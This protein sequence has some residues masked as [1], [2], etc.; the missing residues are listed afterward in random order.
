MKTTTLLTQ[1][2]NLAHTQFHHAE[3]TPLADGD[4]RLR[5][6]QFSFTANNVTYASF[7]ESMH[8]WQFF[9]SP[10]DGFGIIPV[11][12]FATVVQSAHTGVA[13]GER[14]YGYWPFASHATLSPAHLSEYGF[15]DAAPHRAALHPLYNQYA[16]TS[17][18]GF[19]TPDTE[20]IQ[21]I[22]RPLFI[23]SFLID[24]FFASEDFF[25]PNDSKVVAILSSASSKT[26]YGTAHQMH[27]R[28]A[29]MKAE[30]GKT[31]EVVGLT[32]E[33]NRA[34][35]E[36]LG[37]YDRVITY[38]EL[39]KVAADA[40]CVYVDFAGNASLRREIHTRF[41]NLRYSCSIGGTHITNLGNS[42][43]LPGPKAILFFAPAQVKK[44]NAEL[45]AKVFMQHIISAWQQFCTRV[46]T[47]ENATQNARDGTTCKPWLMPQAHQGEAAAQLVY[48]EVLAGKSDAQIGHVL[49]L[50]T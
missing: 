43:D 7:G 34:F 23:T 4:V 26:A 47:T 6:E 2:S 14:L 50:S 9:P 46:M 30:G 10:I 12:G 33:K 21:A 8:Y 29:R 45:G 28:A 11:W 27:L 38:D 44:R 5:I 13:V 39:A 15:S 3:F 25:A 40:P 18:D 35:C 24:D 19:Y 1:K 41:T 49:S 20:A 42:K 37:C 48:D 16:R 31:L 32:S 22:L 36:S 17:R